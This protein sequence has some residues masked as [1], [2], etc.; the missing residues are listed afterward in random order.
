MIKNVAAAILFLSCSASFAQG[1]AQRQAIV[2]RPGTHELTLPGSERRYT[3]V[4]PRG[5]SGDK[6]VPLVMS[7]HY[8]GPLIPYIG[9]GLLDQLVEP[10]LKELGAI[11]VAPDSAADGWANPIAEQHVI[12]L[13]SFIE[14]NYNVDPRKTLLTGYSMGAMGTWYLAPRHPELFEA[15]IPMAGRP[16][17]DSTELEWKTPTLVINSTADELIAIEGTR[18]AVESLQ[19]QGAPIEIV[20]IDNVTHFQIPLYRRHLK[21]AIPWL[22]GVWSQ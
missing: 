21:A 8:G 20:V 16:Q 9:R 15:A 12:E 4:I 17:A 18:A 13:L 5:Y 6:A 14:A 2:T 3:L 10:V 1:Q 19:A 7:L 22:E 11:M